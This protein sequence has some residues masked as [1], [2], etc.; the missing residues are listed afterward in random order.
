MK[1]D[2]LIDAIG[3]IDDE[4]IEEAHKPSRKRKGWPVYL[5]IITGVACVMLAF[6]IG[7]T[8]LLP[9]MGGSSAATDSYYAENGAYVGETVDFAHK[10]STVSTDG[11]KLIVNGSMDIETISIDDTV[12][13]INQKNKELGGYVQY[14]SISS[15]GNYRNYY[16]TIRVPKDSYDTFVEYLKTLGNVTSYTVSTDDITETYSDLEARINSLKA[17]EKRIMELYEKAETIDELLEIETRL[18]DIRYEIDSLETSIKNYDLLTTYATIEVCL[19]ETK[20]FTET[21]QNFFERIGSAL[22][23]GWINFTNGLGDL[24]VGFSYNIWTILFVGA[25]VF[26][27]VM[28]VRHIIRKNRK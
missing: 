2:K 14:S 20:V 12:G 15:S 28:L 22:K 24:L 10:D 21:K 13:K 27:I 11:Q 8:A 4:Y 7:I 9:K 3:M 26:G 25:V 17:E 5:K 18:T 19:Y 16:A 23:N 1:Q 6:F